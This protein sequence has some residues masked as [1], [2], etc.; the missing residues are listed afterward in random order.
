MRSV[1]GGLEHLTALESPKL[2]CLGELRLMKL[3]KRKRAVPICHGYALLIVFVPSELSSLDKVVEL[4]KEMRYLTALQS[5]HISRLP[6]K[7]LPRWIG[8]LSSLHSLKISSCEHFE[9]SLPEALRELTSLQRL[10]VRWCNGLLK[11]LHILYSLSS[12]FGLLSNL[13]MLIMMKRKP[14]PLYSYQL[15]KANF[16]K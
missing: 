14:K 15:M 7:G 11:T 12:G 4:P 6:L 13:I 16:S 8:C 5:L 1:S 10:E 9:E 3:R 2:S